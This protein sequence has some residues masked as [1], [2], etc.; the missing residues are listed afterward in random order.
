MAA[1]KKGRKKTGGRQ[2]GT[3]NKIAHTAKTAIESVFE[4]IGGIAAFRKWAAKNSGEFYT[5]VYVKL[6]PKNLI[7]EVDVTT[8]PVST[9]VIESGVGI[10]RPEQEDG[11]P[12]ALYRA[13]LMVWKSQRLK[14]FGE[15]EHEG[16]RP[17]TRKKRHAKADTK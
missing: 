17:A 16:R 5:K 13:R 1:F 10:N 3:G 14:I 8:N 7:A 12:Q 6:L 2:P 11:E 4:S 9:V 15:P